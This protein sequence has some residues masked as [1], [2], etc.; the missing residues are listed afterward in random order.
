[1]KKIFTTIIIS[2]FVTAT[3]SALPYFDSYIP[4]EAGDFVFY[5]DNSFTRESYIGILCYDDVT[6]QVKYFAPQNQNLGEKEI[7]VLVT[8]NPDTPYMELTGE[9]IMGQILPESEDVD[10]VNYLHDI[11][12]EFNSHRMDAREDLILARDAKNFLL[13]PQKTVIQNYEQFGGK[14]AITYDAIVP[15]FNIREIKAGDGSSALKCVTIGKINS[16][17]DK[18]FDNFKGIPASQKNSKKGNLKSS[19]SEK[20]SYKNKT[21]TLD[22]QWKKVLNETTN[23][24]FENLFTLGESAMISL[25]ELSLP[26]EDFTKE[27][28]YVTRKILQGSQ[29]SVTDLENSYIKWDSKQTKCQIFAELYNQENGRKKVNNDILLKNSD[30]NLSYLSLA[31]FKDAFDSNVSYFNKILKSYK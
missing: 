5:R 17:D 29:N 3:F 22:S 18:T 14:V 26:G 28:L 16:S 4:D 24:Y 7:A 15:L 20:I 8:L 9:K 13:E 23:T 1:M 31:V 12:Y 6:L 19:K 27:A 25:S 21:I 11:L 2:L 30:G 10:I